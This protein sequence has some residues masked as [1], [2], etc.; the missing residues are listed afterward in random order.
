M[1]SGSLGAFHLVASKTE[2]VAREDVRGVGCMLYGEL[3]KDETAEADLITPT[4]PAFRSLLAVPCHPDARERYGKLV[5]GLLSSCLLNVDE[6]RGREG[7]ISSRKV[8]TNLLAAVL[9]LTVIPPQAPVARDVVEHLFFLISQKLE[10]GDEMA[11]V[12]VH[13]AKTLAVAASGSELLRASVRLLLPAL[14]QY[15]AKIVPR[16][17]DGTLSEQQII[18]I[19]EVW[20]TFATL[21]SL[22]RDDQR[23]RL[24]SVLIPATTLLLRPSQTPPSTVHSSGIA[25]LL[26][27]AASSSASF[28]EATTQLDPSVREVLEMS[29]RKAVEGAAATAVQ[30]SV[31]PQISLRSF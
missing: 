29:I 23:S 9:I 2:S 18:S 27:L 7:L 28:K 1:I 5:H 24:L 20:K 13:C 6:M 25:H 16:V 8:K 14:I 26:S 19:D 22:A 3:L 11:I 17:D 31:K 30:Q 21:L 12:A 15:I 10:E 4:L